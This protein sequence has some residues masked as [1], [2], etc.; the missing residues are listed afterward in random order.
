[1]IDIEDERVT[2]Q[3]LQIRSIPSEEVLSQSAPRNQDRIY[4]P[5]APLAID[6]DQGTTPVS[7]NRVESGKEAC[8]FVP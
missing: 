2:K 1:M 8:N 3:D 4:L 5:V 6:F 7:S